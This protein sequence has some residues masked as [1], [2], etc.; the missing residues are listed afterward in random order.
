MEQTNNTTSG[1]M[2][3]SAQTAH[4]VHGAIK[5]G[6]AIAGAAK[7]VAAGGPYGALAAGLWQNRKTVLKVILVA[8]FIMMLPILFILMLPALIYS[9]IYKISL[10]KYRPF[11]FL[12][13]P[14]K[15]A[16]LILV[17]RL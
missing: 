10:C 2:N 15:M 7:G 8:V 12:C 16:A 3:N 1:T 13:L 11:F 4:A 17:N 5:T 14:D 9:W 6:K